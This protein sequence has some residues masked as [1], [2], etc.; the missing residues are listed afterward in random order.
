MTFRTPIDKQVG[1]RLQ[2]QRLALNMSVESVAQS[3]EIEARQVE[4]WEAGRVRVEA[5]YLL[6]L[7]KLLNV[8]SA[9]FFSAPVG[10]RPEARTPIRLELFNADLGGTASI[11]SLRLLRAFRRISQAKSRERLIAFA[12]ELAD[13]ETLGNFLA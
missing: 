5:R 7:C 11:E 9:Y 2:A 6:L 13:G 4:D 10:P 8:N 3:L 1:Q 12:E